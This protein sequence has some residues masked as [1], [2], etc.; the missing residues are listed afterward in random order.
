MKRPARMEI[1]AMTKTTRRFFSTTAMGSL[2][3]L[4]ATTSSASAATSTDLLACQKQLD[5]QVRGFSSTVYRLLFNCAEKVVECNLAQ[6][7]DA[8]DPTTCLAHAATGCTA[9]PGKLGTE[10]TTRK[11][12]VLSRCG[13]ILPT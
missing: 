7:I 5:G 2:L 9:A 3:V 13:A 12:R 6:E 8:V 1:T 11:A 10:A 4:L